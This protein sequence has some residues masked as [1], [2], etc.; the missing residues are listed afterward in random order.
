MMV[1]WAFTIFIVFAIA[2][3]LS[4]ALVK[5]E[6]ST[7]FMELPPLRWPSFIN[8]FTKTYTRMIWY[9]KEIVPIFIGASIFIWLGKITGIFDFLVR[10]LGYPVR[11]AGMPEAVSPALL[12][13][14]FRRDF[15]AAGLFDLAKKGVIGGQGLLIAAVV[16]TLF[17][18]CVAH[19][20]VT[21][22]ERGKAMAI[23]MALF[24]FPFAFF[25]G[26]VLNLILNA[27]G[28]SL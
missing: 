3:V 16:L 28:V 7:F 26:F 19:F 6:E 10:V 8:V 21:W 5:G 17:V 22:K 23:G 18:P 13:G 2:G 9:F 20:A 25:V 27:L 14:F 15:G 24:I 1:I 12:Y 11:W 4:K